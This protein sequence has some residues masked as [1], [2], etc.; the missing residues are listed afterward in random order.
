MLDAIAWR[1]KELQADLLP[2]GKRLYAQTPGDFVRVM[3]SY[4][5]EWG[6]LL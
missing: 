6:G 2:L 4:W 1:R 3:T 5:E